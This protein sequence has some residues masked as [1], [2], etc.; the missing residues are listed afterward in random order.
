MTATDLERE[1]VA[2]MVASRRTRG[3]SQ[4][5]LANLLRDRG[6]PFHQQ[7]VQRIETG[8]RP[9]RMSE[10]IAIGRVLGLRVE[11]D[12]PTPLVGTSLTL[13]CPCGAVYQL[14]AV[15]P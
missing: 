15:T 8:E 14:P 13:T 6:L 7:T 12:M 4:T 2:Q 3:M 10:A 5:K 9:L 1:F 11:I